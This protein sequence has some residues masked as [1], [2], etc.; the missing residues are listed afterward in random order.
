[1]V[2]SVNCRASESDADFYGKPTKLVIK[3]SAKV[4]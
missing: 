1:M 4:H 2:E 3:T